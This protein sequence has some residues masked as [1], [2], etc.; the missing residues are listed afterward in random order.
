MNVTLPEK[1]KLKRKYIII[2]GLIIIF[3]IISLLIAFY[4][5]FYARIDIAKLIGIN[6][7][8]R[9]GQKDEEEIETLK[10]GFM[11]LFNNSIENSE[12]QY[13][14]K[15]VETDKDL[16]YSQYE[17][18]ES[19]VNSYD[20]ETH[21]PYINIK[22]EIIDEYNKEIEDVFINMANK[23]LQTENRNIIYTLQYEATIENDIL[24]LIIRSNLKEGA[25]AQRL[26]IQTF[27]YDLKNNK[28]IT[29]E[30]MIERKQLNANDVQNKINGEI[31]S[32]QKRVQD[33]KSLGYTIFERKVKGQ[34]RSKTF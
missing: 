27:N 17:K 24:S 13:N 4:V 1:E 18:K 20:L 22:S 12:G 5:Q 28:E 34:K 7:E 9:F 31:T 21:I 30:E 19:K 2:Y 8:E 11:N 29:L 14:D 3:C 25:N 33:L 26:I 32:Q 6:Q 15:K 16:V 10:T 23:V